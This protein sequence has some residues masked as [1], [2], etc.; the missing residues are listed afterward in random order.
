MS[1]ELENGAMVALDFER[2]SG[3]QGESQSILNVDGST[4]GLAWEWCPPFEDDS[5]KLLHY[6]DVA[7]KVD[8]WVEHFPTFGWD[9]V[10]G[11][12]LLAFVELVDGHDSII[13]SENWLAFNYAVLLA[14]YK[15][16]AEGKPINV[17]LSI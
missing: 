16:A 11:R 1:L 2:A 15:C 7:G 3:F 6:V 13:L 4:G 9:E 8:K 12:P 5:V 10:H 17:S 14:I